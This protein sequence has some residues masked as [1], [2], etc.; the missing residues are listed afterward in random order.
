M[1]DEDSK[2][3]NTSDN[4]PFNDV[5]Q[6]NLERR[7]L[8]TGSAGLAA[9]AALFSTSSFIQAFAG[10]GKGRGQ[11]RGAAGG[12]GTLLGFTAV[13]VAAGGGIEPAI[14]AEYEFD[15]ILPWGEPLQP[16]GPA[17]SLPL[18]P[19]DQENQIGIGHDGM[20][21]FPIR[22]AGKPRYGWDEDGLLNPWNGNSL[23][24]GPVRN[25]GVLCLN[26]EFGTNDHVLRKS[27]SL[28]YV[29]CK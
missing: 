18:N 14:S 23:G 3:S 17:F 8:L 29:S 2:G 20:W 21:F 7:R 19:A 27:G 22:D 5:L 25:H 11:A 26:N 13:P 9:G 16:D 4:R 1:H 24:N 12:S 15:V 10:P 28:F 6:V